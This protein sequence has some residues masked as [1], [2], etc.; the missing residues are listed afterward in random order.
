[1]ENDPL[2]YILL[3]STISLHFSKNSKS[4]KFLRGRRVFLALKQ[5]FDPRKGV[6]EIE[7]SITVLN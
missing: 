6:A 4:S 5:K 2:D 3:F 7:I 1:M